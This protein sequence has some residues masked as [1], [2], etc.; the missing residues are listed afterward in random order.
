[1][2]GKFTDKSEE[3]SPCPTDSSIS[4]LIAHGLTAVTYSFPDSKE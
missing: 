2:K 4:S 3:P 1:M